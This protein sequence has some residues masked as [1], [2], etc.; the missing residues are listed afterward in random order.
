MDLKTAVQNPANKR[1]LGLIP[2][3]AVRKGESAGEFVCIAG[4]HRLQ[5]SLQVNG[6]AKVRVSPTGEVITVCEK[7]GTLLAIQ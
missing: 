6:H 1:A 5:A 2:Q 4:T 7:D 3:A